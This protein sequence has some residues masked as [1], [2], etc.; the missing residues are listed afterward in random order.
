MDYVYECQDVV[1]WSLR[2]YT[3]SEIEDMSRS[4]AGFVEYASGMRFDLT[5]RR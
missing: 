1:D 4:A 2:K 5:R 3:M